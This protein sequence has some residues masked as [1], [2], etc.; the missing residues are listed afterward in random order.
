[1]MII[2]QLQR[3]FPSIRIA[4]PRMNDRD[5]LE[6]FYYEGPD[7]L[8]IN[9]WGIQEPKHGELVHIYDIDLVLVPLLAYDM[10]GNRLGYG[11]GFY[12]RFLNECRQDCSAIGLS[13]FEP[14]MQL[15][16]ISATD[17]KIDKVITPER[18]ITF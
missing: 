14:E 11:K 16:E 13:M 6:H 2:N 8:M 5:E 9:S 17:F 3:D 18:C 12:D 10:K 7:Q 4:V 1:M 15:P